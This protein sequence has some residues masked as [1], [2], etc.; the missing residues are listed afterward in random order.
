LARTA[1]PHLSPAG[2]TTLDTWWDNP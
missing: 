2:Y 1:Q